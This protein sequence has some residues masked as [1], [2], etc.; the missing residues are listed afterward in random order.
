[1]RRHLP[2][3]SKKSITLRDVIAHVTNMKQQLSVDIKA[4]TMAIRGLTGRVDA[5]EGRMNSFERR[6]NSL[7]ENLTAR[8]NALD[9]DLMAT[10]NDTLR[11]RRHVG[12]VIP[13]DD[14]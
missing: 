1:M 3:R 5:L 6:M 10:I 13:E 2:R 4:N 12:M 14:D 9:E 11:I 8:I 7:E